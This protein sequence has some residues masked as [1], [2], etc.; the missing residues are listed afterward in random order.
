M[1][2]FCPLENVGKIEGRKRSD[3]IVK[4]TTINGWEISSDGIYAGKNSELTDLPIA[5]KNWSIDKN[6]NGKLKSLTLSENFTGNN[7]EFTDS[8]FTIYYVSL[9][10]DNKLH[11]TQKIIYSNAVNS[12]RLIN[13]TELET[14]KLSIGDFDFSQEKKQGTLKEFKIVS[15]VA[16]TDRTI[17][18]I[19]NATACD[20]GPQS[21]SLGN[22]T[23]T[24]LYRYG[25]PQKD[26]TVFLYDGEVTL[27]NNSFVGDYLFETQVSVPFNDQVKLAKEIRLVFQNDNFIPTPASVVDAEG[28]DQ[29]AVIFYEYDEKALQLKCLYIAVGE[30]TFDK[31]ALKTCH[32]KQKLLRSKL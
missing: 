31:S 3:I 25:F 6:G 21:I 7:F 5:S 4:T 13:G 18:S 1:K 16:N 2:Y 17:F 15:N 14:E 11:K 24:K 22:S 23:A 10:P 20:I 26:G 12:L 9:T 32:L 19:S 8:G 29:G 30:T 28:N 27:T